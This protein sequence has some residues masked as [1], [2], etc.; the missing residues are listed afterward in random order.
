VRR[1]SR[2]SLVGDLDKDVGISSVLDGHNTNSVHAA[3]SGT[4]FSVVTVE[5]ANTSS[6]KDG[7]VLELSASNGRAVVG[8]ENKLGLS[9]SDRLDGGLVTNLVLSRSNDKGEFLDH[10]VSGVNLLSQR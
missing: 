9:I 10:V 7:E 6:S 5:V 4:K 8:N 3:R 2:R 1:D